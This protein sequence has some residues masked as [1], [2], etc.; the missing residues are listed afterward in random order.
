MLLVTLASLGT[1]LALLALSVRRHAPRACTQ[2]VSWPRANRRARAAWSTGETLL[3]ASRSELGS[4]A[5]SAIARNVLVYISKTI[6]E[7]RFIS[8]LNRIQ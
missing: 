6:V 2:Q 5:T 7:M 8:S 1:L 3:T 4:P